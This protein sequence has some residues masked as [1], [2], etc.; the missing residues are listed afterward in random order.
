MKSVRAVYVSSCMS[1]GN[2][3][4][5]YEFRNNGWRFVICKIVAGKFVR[6][7]VTNSRG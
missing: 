4:G 1:F 7:E 5:S 6:V 3:A 2:F